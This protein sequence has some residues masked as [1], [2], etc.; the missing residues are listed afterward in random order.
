MREWRENWE[1]I[2][3][4]EQER[5]IDLIHA[6]KLTCTA[7]PLKSYFPVHMVL[8]AKACPDF[9]WKKKEKKERKP[10]TRNKI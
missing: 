3:G 5:N 9:P 2:K 4:E 8:G 10:E 6:H 1:E 7:V